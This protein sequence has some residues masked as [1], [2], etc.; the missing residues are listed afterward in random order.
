MNQD[1]YA[2]IESLQGQVTDISYIMLAAAR[3][4]AQN[5]GGDVV[6]VLLGNGSEGLANTLAADRVIYVDDP[7]LAY[8]NS[9]AYLKVLASLIRQN[10][11]R[12]V[13]FGNTSIGADLASCLSARLDLPL[14]NSCHHISAEGM[15]ISQVCGGK[16]MTES[17]LS[18]KT[19]LIT[20]L[21]GGYKPEL[22]QSDAAPNIT[23][24]DA[25]PLEDLR[26]NLKQ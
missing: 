6:A 16:I 19:T 17:G 18:D 10:E 26:I 20:I 12:A 23:Q 1:I 21:P 14:A 9:D 3:S 2:V 15:L 25:P 22:G 8:F 11:P 13:L 24:V 7:A 4:L 5:S